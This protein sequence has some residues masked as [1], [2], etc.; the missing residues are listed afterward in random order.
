MLNPLTGKLEEYRVLIRGTD[1]ELWTHEMA[2]EYG[3]L[4]QGV[5]ERINGTNTIFFVPKHKVPK[6]RIVT[7]GRIVADVR[8]HK[9][10]THRVRLTVGGDRIEYPG[11]L[12]TPTADIT[13]AKILFNSVL[14]TPDARF[15]TLDI[16]KTII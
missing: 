16:K 6:G 8:P 10:D 1:R 14:S 13:T 9:E 11:D 12:H 7:Y 3:R 5:G 2:N 15:M 4:A